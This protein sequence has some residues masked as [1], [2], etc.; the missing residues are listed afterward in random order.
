MNIE[1]TLLVGSNIHKEQ[2]IAGVQL[3]KSTRDGKVMAINP[4]QM[5]YNFRTSPHI[6]TTATEMLAELTAVAKALSSMEGVESVAGINELDAEVNDSHNLIAT[7]L[8]NADKAAILFGQHVCN[9]AD[10]SKLA[11][12]ASA[13]ATMSGASFGTFSDGANSAG[14]HLAG[15]VP[16]RGVGAGAVKVGKNINEMLN[17]DIKAFILHGVEPELDCNASGNARKAMDGAD[18][19]IAMTAFKDGAVSEYADV[20]LPTAAFSETSG[21]FVNVA[22]TWQTF[23]AAVAAKGE[24]R[25]AWKI[26]RV[27][28][29]LLELPR[30]DYVS[31]EE[32]LTELQLILDSAENRLGNWELPTST[33]G[34]DSTANVSSIYQVDAIVRRAVA[35][36][37]TLDG[38]AFVQS[39]TQSDS[40]LGKAEAIS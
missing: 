24:A 7:N 4:T 14:A 5:S 15:A 33:A 28:A 27:L 40:Q 16:H 37:E 2:P 25:P 31:S 3:R 29:N 39:D 9:H 20:M 34:T 19:V 30:Y 17:G 21:T 10:F 22:G 26:L 6:V 35:L 36:Q 18:L 13:I 23:K 8:K 32:V 11:A 1:A 38:Q 12:I